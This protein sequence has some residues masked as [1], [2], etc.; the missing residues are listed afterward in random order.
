MMFYVSLNNDLVLLF[1]L[2]GCH[3]CWFSEARRFVVG[4]KI[5]RNR[6]VGPPLL[7]ADSF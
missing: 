1:G 2:Y 3:R 4:L 6:V 5:W 7:L